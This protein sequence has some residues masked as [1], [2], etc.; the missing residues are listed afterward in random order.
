M[1]I[2]C[3]LG[4]H[5]QDFSR[6]AHAV[7]E[8]A[9]KTDYEFTVQTGVTKYNFKYIQNHFDYCSKD[10]MNQLMD[11]ADILFLHGGWGGIEYAIDKGKRC[12]G[13]PRIEGAEHIHNQEQLV[14]K[15]DKMRC[16]IGCFNEEQLGE[17]IKR[18]RQMKVKPLEKGDAT[19]CINNALNEWFGYKKI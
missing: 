1:K 3:S 12:V 15:L 17:C 4:T 19:V 6:L 16:I 8:L 10:K 7:D 5:T 13:V 18:A 14:R 2:L 11:E 9:G